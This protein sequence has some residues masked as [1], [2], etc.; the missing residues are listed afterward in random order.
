MTII[1]HSH[2]GHAK[3]KIVEKKVDGG[4]ENSFIH[5]LPCPTLYYALRGSVIKI[6]EKGR[7]SGRIFSILLFKAVW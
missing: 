6:K 3:L 1:S 2:A 5:N 4:G 7:L